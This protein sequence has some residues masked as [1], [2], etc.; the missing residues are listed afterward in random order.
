MSNICL[1]HF[2]PL[3]V[4][5]SWHMG[6]MGSAHPLVE[7]NVS[8]KFEGNPFISKG[9]IERTWI[10]DGP[11]NTIK[12]IQYS[13]P[14]HFVVGVQKGCMKLIYFCYINEMVNTRWE[15]LTI[16]LL[17]LYSDCNVSLDMFNR[18]RLYDISGPWNFS[19]MLCV[20]IQWKGTPTY[21]IP[22]GNLLWIR[23]NILAV[24]LF[25]MTK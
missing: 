3:T 8:F 18:I 5:L 12:R 2:L 10:G 4:T 20:G 22:T 16:L 19:F 17:Y 25:I 6:N 21:L 11:T 23:R 7:V 9:V 24:R 15:L 13:P 14:P 1:L